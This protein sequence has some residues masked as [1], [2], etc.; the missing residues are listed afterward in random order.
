MSG[1]RQDHVFWYRLRDNAESA[2]SDDG[3]SRWFCSTPTMRGYQGLEPVLD[4]CG[5]GVI[6]AGVAARAASSKIDGALSKK[7]VERYNLG[8]EG[9]A[10]Q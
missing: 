4:C 10:S 6:T 7:K 5:V 3:W 9:E 1:P 2:A 8:L